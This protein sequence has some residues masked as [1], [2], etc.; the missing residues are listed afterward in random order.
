[1]AAPA[2]SAAATSPFLLPS[3][4]HMFPSSKPCLPND[5]AFKGSNSSSSTVLILAAGR[6]CFCRCEAV[7]EAGTVLPQRGVDDGGVV[8]TSTT[9]RSVF[10]VAVGVSSALVL[11]LA[12]FDD[13]LAAGLSPEEKLKLCD[14]ACEIKLTLFKYTCKLQAEICSVGTMVVDAHGWVV[15]R[16]FGFKAQELDEDQRWLAG[17][18][19]KPEKMLTTS[20]KW[21]FGHLQKRKCP[22]TRGGENKGSPGALN[23]RVN[24]AGGQE[25]ELRAFVSAA[26]DACPSDKTPLRRHE[27]H[28]LAV[29]AAAHLRDTAVPLV[30]HCRIRGWRSIGHQR[31]G[32]TASDTA[33][34]I[35][36]MALKASGTCWHC[37]PCVGSSV[38]GASHWH[39]PYHQDGGSGF[40]D[41]DAASGSEQFLYMYHSTSTP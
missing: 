2:S 23:W 10:G 7:G 38:A 8:C 35:K 27:L 29:V 15:D 16:E 40:G 17:L 30:P 28:A 12:A 32:T 21:T 39:H 41:S 5:R 24:D 14:A 26:F 4:R 11:G 1:M 31:W 3:A 18:Q 34:P 37:K 6:C 19:Q 25:D 9:Q 22:W 13:A 20:R 36:D 33:P